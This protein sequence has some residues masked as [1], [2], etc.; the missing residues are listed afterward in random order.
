MRIGPGRGPPFDEYLSPQLLPSKRAVQRQANALYARQRR[1]S[2][3]QSLVQCGQLLRRVSRARG[4]DV[5]HVAI[6]GLKPEILVL[7]VAQSSW[8]ADRPHQHAPTTSAAW[9]TISAFCGSD[10][11]SRVERF[12]PRK[13]SAGS[14]C[15]VIH[16]GT[17][18]NTTPVT[19]DSRNAKPSTGSEGLASIG[20]LCALGNASARIVRVPA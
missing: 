14:A 4:I 13:A 16:A 7:E 3:F 5:H 20:R 8:S 10:P 11:R 1:E 15:D 18:P 9:K 6:R 19:S 17:M 2:L 12:A